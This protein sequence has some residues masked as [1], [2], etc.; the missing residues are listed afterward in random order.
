MDTMQYFINLP[1]EGRSVAEIVD[2]F[3]ERIKSASKSEKQFQELEA[4]INKKYEDPA[5]SLIE[6]GE[7]CSSIL[8]AVNEFEKERL[9]R[10][11]QGKTTDKDIALLKGINERVKKSDADLESLYFNE[12][13]TE[14]LTELHDI[15]D[16]LRDWIGTLRDIESFTKALEIRAETA[17]KVLEKGQKTE[18]NTLKV[19]V[20]GGHWLT[21]NR[22]TGRVCLNK[23]TNDLNP[24]SQEFKNLLR[25]MENKNH[26]ITYK[27][28]LGET[29]S[30]ANKRNLAFVVRNLKEALGIL[31]KKGAKNKDCIKNTKGHGYKLIT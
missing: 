13:K 5:S 17:E 21:L 8:A 29:I 3:Q 24:E 20:V 28:I 7:V 14:K 15:L 2:A 10:I 23:H 26:Q 16:I 1:L 30:K 31:P 6:I 27:E 9:P 25:L 4:R 12:K 18:D 19:K 22:H 11:R